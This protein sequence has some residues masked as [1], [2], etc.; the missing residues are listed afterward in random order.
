MATITTS[1]GISF[2]FK[3]DGPCGPRVLYPAN[4]EIE[5]LEAATPRGW[6]VDYETTH[7]E[8]GYDSDRDCIRYSAP[9]RRTQGTDRQRQFEHISEFLEE[10]GR[11]TTMAAKMVRPEG[12]PMTERAMVRTLQE[13]VN[14]LNEIVAQMRTEAGKGTQQ[15]GKEQP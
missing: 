5:D 3:F 14:R 2:E 9:L 1:T 15:L 11:V 12:A 10:T 13:S 6:E 7:T 4:A 8:A